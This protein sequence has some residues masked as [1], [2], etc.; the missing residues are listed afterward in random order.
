MIGKKYD[1]GKNAPPK[2]RNVINLITRISV[3]GIASITA[4][5]IILLSAFNGIEEM[6]ENLY[7]AYD[8]DITIRPVVGKTCSE[9]R[10]DFDAL[11]EIEGVKNYSRAIEEVV[12]LKHEK[13]RVN[14]QLIG[15][16]ASFIEM[17]DMRSH[18]VDGEAILDNGDVYGIIGATLLDKLDGYIPESVGYETVTCF[19]P[20][21][22][23]KI[24][25]G[26]NPFRTKQVRVSGRMN[27]N[28]EVNAQNFIVPLRLS[29]EMLRYDDQISAIYIDVDPSF[30]NEDVRDRIKKWIGKDFVVKTSFEKNELIYKTSK[31]EKV[32]VMVILLFIFILAAFSL[33]ASLTMLFVEKL[34][35]I[36]TLRSF[37]A[38]QK[39]IFNI[40]FYEGLLISIKGIV[41]GIVIGYTI[42]LAQIYFGLLTMPNSGGESFPIAISLKDGVLIIFLVTILS[43]LFSYF[44][45]KYLIYKNISQ[46][47]IVE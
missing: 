1:R 4:A 11:E 29:R 3:V 16:E 31:S 8:T 45:V 2:K 13:K 24:G 27:Y 36:R 39:F 28:R 6:I 12:I 35:N 5:L 19:V 34:P 42:C 9:R 37:G 30:E 40:F 17:T 7:S 14:A 38:D 46:D 26:K 10:L 22:K 15:V 43:F 18:M 20:K 47:R 44:P 23:L 33:V 21:R 41:I 25:F 32:I